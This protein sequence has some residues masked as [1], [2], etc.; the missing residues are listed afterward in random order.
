M[1]IS[2]VS[3][4]ENPLLSRLDVEFEAKEVTATPS[5]REL[6][7]QLAALTSADEKLLIVD[8]LGQEYG[9]QEVKGTARVYKTEKDL[10]RTETKKLIAR[11]FG[12]EAVAK[13]KPEATK[14][15]TE[16]AAAPAAK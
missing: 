11:N 5:R 7:Q 8:V 4:K 13:K 2:I 6:R 15:A 3:K 14:P 12:K 10:K 9:T 16:A 1:K